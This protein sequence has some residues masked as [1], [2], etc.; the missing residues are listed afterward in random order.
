MLWVVLV[1][2]AIVLLLV[3]WVVGIYNRLVRTRNRVDNA[4]AQIEVQLKRRHDLIPNLV[5]TV[6]G[7]AA[8]ERGTFEA[9]TQARVAAQQAQGQISSS[10]SMVAASAALERARM[11][12]RQGNEAECLSAVG[13]AKLISGAR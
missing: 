11:L 10:H 8:H 13:Q 3:L 4:W 12:D 6:K 2:V 9:V 7:Y 1:I 5:E